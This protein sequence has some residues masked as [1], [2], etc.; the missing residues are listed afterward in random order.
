[1]RAT[2]NVRYQHKASGTYG[3]FYLLGG[4]YQFTAVGFTGGSGLMWQLAGDDSTC[5][6]VNDS[7]TAVSGDTIYLSPG[8]YKWVLTNE[9]DVSFVIARVPGE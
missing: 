4:I 5:L 6:S 8:T 1:M 3:P 9:T 2:E 7:L